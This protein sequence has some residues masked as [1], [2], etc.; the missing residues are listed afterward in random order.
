MPKQRGFSLSASLDANGNVVDVT[1]PEDADV[2]V[3]QRITHGKLVQA[4]KIMVDRGLKVI[5]DIDDDLAAIDPNNPAWKAM[6]PQ[7]G[8]NPDHN[9]LNT[10]RACNIA[11]LVTV[12]SNA[13]LSRY[14]RHGRGVV[15]NNCVP[16]R[17]TQLE[18]SDSDVLGWGG[19]LHVHPSDVQVLGPTIALLTASGTRFRVV[20]P[21]DG[22]ARALGCAEDAI[23]STGNRDLLTEWPETLTTLGVGVAP[24]ADT[25][26]N[27]AK[28]WLKLL[29]YSA[30]GVPWVASPRVEYRR[31]HELSHGGFLVEKHKHWLRRTR[32]LLTSESL[33]REMSEAG[34][35]WAANHTIEGNAWRWAEAW[36]IPLGNA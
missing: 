14:A 22:V 18:H 8:N 1:W 6:H 4:I 36:S 28:S 16:E 12:S 5:I 30:L 17:Y 15:L 25:R 10:Q 13:L 35:T 20:G 32:E 26:F 9:W 7:Y 11:S 19:A 2:I 27:A 31:A 33:R 23:E 24:L 3:L 29:E 34:R 21:G